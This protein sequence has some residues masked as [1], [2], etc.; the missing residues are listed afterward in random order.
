MFFCLVLC[1]RLFSTTGSQ[2]PLASD[3]STS[4]QKIVLKLFDHAFES[5]ELMIIDSSGKGRKVWKSEVI[6]PAVIVEPPSAGH[7]WVHS[8]VH[9]RRHGQ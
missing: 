5:A 1:Y 6:R 2:L 8:A 3:A 9:S 7:M 4:D